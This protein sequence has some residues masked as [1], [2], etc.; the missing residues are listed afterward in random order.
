MFPKN[1][2]DVD[3][4]GVAK[5]NGVRNDGR[6]LVQEWIDRMKDQV[7]FSFLQFFP[8]FFYQS[9]RVCLKMY[10]FEALFLQ[11]G[12]Y[13]WNKQQLLSLNPKKT[14]YLLGKPQ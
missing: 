8:L 2:S 10:N 3:Y 7:F 12:H 5:Y 4:P 13:V 14:S 9:I 1:M 11:G 6:N